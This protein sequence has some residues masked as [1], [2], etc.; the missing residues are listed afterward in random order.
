[1]ELNL[2]HIARNFPLRKY[3]QLTITLIYYFHFNKLI[4]YIKRLLF[5]QIFWHLWYITFLNVTVICRRKGGKNNRKF[6]LFSPP[7]ET[8]FSY[9]FPFPLYRFALMLSLSL[10]DFHTVWSLPF[11]LFSGSLFSVFWCDAK[12]SVNSN[13]TPRLVVYLVTRDKFLL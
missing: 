10:I 11:I 3:A 2:T 8:L 4:N 5:D 13:L 6:L 9:Q 12:T 1:V 7:I